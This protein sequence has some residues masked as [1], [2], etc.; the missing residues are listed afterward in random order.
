MNNDCMKNVINKAIERVRAEIKI[1][2]IIGQYKN[3]KKVGTDEHEALCDWH[4]DTKL[5]SFKISDKKNICKC[6][7]CGEGKDNIGYFAYKEN[8]NYVEAAMILA[9]KKEIISNNEY[10]EFS[11]TKF[12]DIKAKKIELHYIKKDKKKFNDS[13]APD[14]VL[15]NVYTAFFKESSLS[16]RHHKYLKEKRFLSDEDIIE[17]GYFTF[18]SM[19]IMKR[20]QERLK[21]DYGYNSTILKGVPGFY[22]EKE[23][24]KFMFTKNKGIGICIKNAE[25]LIVGIQ[26][27]KDGINL[28]N[29]YI[30]FSSSIILKDDNLSKI[31]DC[32]TGSHSRIDIIYPK[33]IK[34]KTIFITEGRFKAK[35]ISDTFSCIAISVQGVGNWKNIKNELQAIRKKVPIVDFTNIF[36]AYDADVA[37]NPQV[38]DQA[39]KM[40][41]SLKKN[42][43][44]M[45]F[46]YVMWSID[47]G[48][49]IDDL[50]YAGH[51]DM[52]ESMDI[53][54][55][56]TIY[57]SFIYKV[58]EKYGNIIEN[59][60][61]KYILKKYFDR[62]IITEQ[63]FKKIVQYIEFRKNNYKNVV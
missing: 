54:K 27:R 19:S 40:A 24:G 52:L 37:Y 30:W 36:I 13:I 15:N 32:A 22:R 10:D 8:L 51:K 46:R 14:E 21:K 9:L 35:C 43:P 55:F 16:N 57:R 20:F 49:G 62:M 33:K 18:P 4:N 17:G 60:V 3:L 6:F 42:L 59:K 63:N 7:F 38:F 44:G 25:G 2:S 34:Y 53:K 39:V 5:G 41:E 48:K 28:R 1:S 50:I 58:E 47:Y 56:E 26:I 61:P 11:K 12:S 23:S 45:K 29:K 31:Y